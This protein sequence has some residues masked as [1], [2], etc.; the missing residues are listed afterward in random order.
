MKIAVMGLWHLGTVTAAC[1]AHAGHTVVGLDFDEETIKKLNGGAPPLFE[2]G[3]EELLKDGLKNGNLSFTLDAPE[4]LFGADALWVSYDTPV[5]EED[6][7]D[8]DF[9]MERVKSVFKHIEGDAVVIVSSQLPVGSVAE[10]EKAFK[11]VSPGKRVGFASSPENLRLGRAISAFTNPDRVVVGSRTDGDRA[12]IKNLLLPI[13]D[14]VEW[15]SVESAEM[16]K[17]AINSF[18]AV[19]VTFANELASI[20]ERVGADAKEVERGLKSEARIGPGAYVSPG[21]AFAGGTLARDV[22]FLT[23]LG[24]KLGV[25]AELIGSVRKSNERHKGWIKARLKDI[26]KN[27]KGKNVAVLG[28]T[29]KPGTDTLRR[30]SSVELCLALARD[31][32][33]VR[34]HDPAVKALPKELAKKIAL[35]ESP[36]EAMKGASAVVVATAWPEYKSITA[37]DVTTVMKRPAVVDPAGFLRSTLGS[38]EIPYFAVGT[39]TKQTR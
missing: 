28:L 29:Y 9:V 24:K 33:K 19:S 31:G 34:G 32:A 30:S 18:L 13:T 39:A 3:L 16:T 17:H 23:S 7:A 15:M 10:L 20:C 1:L 5:D 4:A 6:N 37:I 27:L 38:G 26:L 11:K 12:K 36:L 21:V 35:F 22:A 8:V 14:R 25:H 2:P